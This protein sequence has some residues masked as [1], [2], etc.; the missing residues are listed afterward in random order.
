M[1]GL[2][3][4]YLRQEDVIAAGVLDMR[5]AIEDVERILAMYARGDVVMPPKTV[6]DFKDEEGTEFFEI[7]AQPSDLMSLKDAL[8]QA[9]FKVESAEITAIPQSTVRV[10]GKD[11]EK[12]L[13]LLEALEDH[14]DVQKVH[15]NMDIPDEVM[16]ALGG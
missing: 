16:S 5:K 11:A 13:K 14:D 15:S 7:Y 3:F 12:L 9:G 4:L 1:P 6:L 2:E 8:T 10:E